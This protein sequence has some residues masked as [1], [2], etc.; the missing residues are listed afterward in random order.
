MIK[1]KII[2]TSESAVY[3]ILSVASL[4]YIAVELFYLFYTF[5]SEITNLNF[6]DGKSFALTAVPIFFNI[7]ISLEILETF[8]NKDSNILRKVK[9]IIFVALTAICRKIIIMDI[10]HTDYLLLFGISALVISL[11]L[12]YYFLSRKIKKHD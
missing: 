1:D 10:K 9:I 8:K 11:C 12:G 2:E 5:Y 7:L 4:L 6:L 3:F